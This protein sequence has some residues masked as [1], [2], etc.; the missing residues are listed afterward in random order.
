M[1]ELTQQPSTAL[2][3]MESQA[4][5][6]ELLQR[7]A[8]AFS[9]S[10]IVPAQ[11]RTQIEKKEY[12]KVVGYEPNPSGLANCIVAMNMA[13]RMRADELIVMQN[14]YII[15]GRPSWSSQWVIAMINGCGKF[16]PL[17]FKVEDLGTKEV[18]YVEYVYDKISK[19][20]EPVAKK[21]TVHDFSCVAYATDK[22]SGVE[23]ESTKVSISMAVKEG[24]YTKTGSK[25]QTMPEMM[26]KYRAA[27]FFGSIYAPE[28]KMGLITVEE[29]QDMPV[30]LSAKYPDAIPTEQPAQP[31]VTDLPD[32]SEQSATENTTDGVNQTTGETE[33]DFD[34]NP[35]AAAAAENEFA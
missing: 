24:W 12:G 30:D 34:V 13:Q 8:Q 22:E 26:L 20:R 2:M 25:W 28:L 32:E 21:I 14:L 1:N 31:T 15:E 10:T 29:S 33:Q 23:L 17:R 7:K 18:D 5:G 16:S 35:G 6:W 27:S 4:K 19:K 3:D 11:Y 9:A